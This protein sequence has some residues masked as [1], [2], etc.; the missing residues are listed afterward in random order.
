SPL[1]VNLAGALVDPRAAPAHLLDDVARVR[2]ENLGVV[3]VVRTVE[4]RRGARDALLELR[5][6]DLHAVPRAERLIALAAKRRT[7]I[8]QGEIDI[9]KNRLRRD[10][11]LQSITQLP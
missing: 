8:D 7:G 5:R 11:I 2:D 10:S 1:A 6:I 9:E 3:H 4:E